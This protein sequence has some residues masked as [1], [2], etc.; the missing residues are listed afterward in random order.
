M[1]G[2]DDDRLHQLCF[3][4]RT[5]AHTRFMIMA[6]LMDAVELEQLSM[7]HQGVFGDNLKE[8]S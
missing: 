6:Q 2:A 5:H 1:A 7:Q 4:T 3:V 8:V